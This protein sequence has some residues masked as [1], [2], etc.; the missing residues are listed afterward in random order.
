[1]GLRQPALRYAEV[2]FGTKGSA[3][4]K[5]FCGIVRSIVRRSLEI[6]EYNGIGFNLI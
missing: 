4:S 2:A 5:N 6:D 3:R 1:M